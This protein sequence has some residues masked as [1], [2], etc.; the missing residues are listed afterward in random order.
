MN[1]YSMMEAYGDQ[2][3]AASNFFYFLG[4][5]HVGNLAITNIVIG[6]VDKGRLIFSN[7]FS[8]LPGCAT[9]MD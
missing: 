8:R 7:Y 9:D 1:T 2:A 4:S 6:K 5:C 3:A